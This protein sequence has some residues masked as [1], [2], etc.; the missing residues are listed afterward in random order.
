MKKVY[1]FAVL[2]AI[3]TLLSAAHNFTINGQDEASIAVGDSVAVYFEF[4]SEGNAA[5]YAITISAMGMELPVMDTQ[6]Q[7]L[8]DGGAM[9]ETGV[10]GIFAFGFSNFVSFPEAATIIFTVTDDGVSDSVTLSFEQLDSDYSIVGSVTSEGSWIDLPVP[11]ALVYSFYNVG[12]EEVMELMED[13]SLEALLAYMGE[14]RYLLSEMT[15]ILGTYQ[16]FVPDDLPEATCFVGV[17]SLLDLEGS[18]VAPDAQVLIV[19]GHMTG[20]NFLYSEPD[21]CFEGIVMDAQENPV[22]NAAILITNQNNP[23]DFAVATTDSTGV[24]SVPL[25]DGTYGF[26]V[27]HFAY[28]PYQGDFEIAG[29]DYY[30]EIVLQGYAI[31]DETVAEAKSALSLSLYPNP[32]NPEVSIAYSVESPGETQLS[33]YDIRGKLVYRADRYD[34]SAGTGL[35]RWNGVDSAGKSAGSGVYLMMVEHGGDKAVRKALLLK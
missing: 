7:P 28:M 19:N 4:E 26:A 29:G 10:D 32:F 12:L 13:F 8:E 23:N 30:E 35:F 22:N 2:I 11:G 17:L 1:L 6:D 21:G 34:V 24:F 25:L 3:S 15:G 16:I 14:G 33:I 18:Y 5:D 31:D 27:T 20:V 9:D